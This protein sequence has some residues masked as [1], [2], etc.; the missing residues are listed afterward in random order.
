MILQPA[1]GARPVHCAPPE[2]RSLRHTAAL[3][4]F[5]AI[6]GCWITEH[7]SVVH[8]LGWSVDVVP[9]IVIGH[10]E[11]AIIR[12]LDRGNDRLLAQMIGGVQRG[13]IDPDRRRPVQ[14]AIGRHGE[15]DLLDAAE[16]D[17]LPDQVDVAVVVVDCDIEK[18]RCV[19]DGLKS[20]RSDGSAR[21]ADASSSTKHRPAAAKRRPSG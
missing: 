5:A 9:E 6:G 16:A 10:D 15:G 20:V 13:L 8:Q 3:L 2:R 7:R 12:N 17:L 14:S 18:N 19:T 11:T 4:V 1:G 21:S